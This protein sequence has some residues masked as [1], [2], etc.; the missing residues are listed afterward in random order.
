MDREALKVKINEALKA[1]KE[2]KR[3]QLTK[4]KKEMGSPRYDKTFFKGLKW[5]DEH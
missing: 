4:W 5:L 2:S 3:E 1:K